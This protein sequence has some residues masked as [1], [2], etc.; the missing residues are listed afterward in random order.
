MYFPVA[1]SHT[2]SQTSALISPGRSELSRQGASN[3]VAARLHLATRHYAVTE[4]E[5]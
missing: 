5:A 2:F 4:D 3:P 1:V